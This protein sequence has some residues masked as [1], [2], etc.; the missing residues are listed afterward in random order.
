VGK[1]EEKKPFGKFR[2]RLELNV[3]LKLQKIGLSVDLIDL[4]HERDRWQTFLGTA[5]N[6][7]FLYNAENL[8]S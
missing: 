7:R 1:S 8:T 2:S 4:D 3:S 6:L 5:M